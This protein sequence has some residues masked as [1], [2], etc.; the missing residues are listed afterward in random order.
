MRGAG[1]R[2]CVNPGRSAE[3]AGSRL[4]GRKRSEARGHPVRMQWSPDRNENWAENEVE[5]NGLLSEVVMR[6]IRKIC[7]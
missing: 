2:N 5:M 4:Q 1:K 7:H 3:G 6:C